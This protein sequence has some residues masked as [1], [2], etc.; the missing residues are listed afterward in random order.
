MVPGKGSYIN[1]VT[2][3]NT[4]TQDPD[5]YYQV[6]IKYDQ[7]SSQQSGFSGE[8]FFRSNI[9]DFLSR[10]DPLLLLLFY[11][12]YIPIA[13]I[14]LPRIRVRFRRKKIAFK[15]Y[16]QIIRIRDDL[17]LASENKE[18][19]NLE[20]R[21]AK[22]IRKMTFVDA[23]NMMNPRKSILHKDYESSRIA[24]DLLKHFES[25]DYNKISEFYNMIKKRNIQVT[26]KSGIENINEQ[27]IQRADSI[28][29]E[30]NWKKYT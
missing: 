16:S 21:S 26:Q 22:E 18:Y 13:L 17:F 6:S 4:T 29:N 5:Y 8:N 3:L 2:E 10:L 11:I 1:L 15:L 25:S 24:S 19:N 9:I 12:M 20:F 28:L 30:I 14:V 27:C 23:L 7:G